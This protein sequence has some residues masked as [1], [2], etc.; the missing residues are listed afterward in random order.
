MS[1]LSASPSDHVTSDLSDS[2]DNEGHDFGGPGTPPGPPTPSVSSDDTLL[3]TV[4]VP[5]ATV[6]Y[7]SQGLYVK[8]TLRCGHSE[9]GPGWWIVQKRHSELHRF[10]KSLKQLVDHYYPRSTMS[11]LFSSSS[12]D[13]LPKFPSTNLLSSTNSSRKMI[14]ARRQGLHDYFAR[15]MEQQHSFLRHREIR[16]LVLSFLQPPNSSSVPPLNPSW[17]SGDSPSH[18]P[19][20]DV[21]VPSYR[22][23]DSNSEQFPVRAPAVH[24]VWLVPRD[25]VHGRLLV[26]LPNVQSVVHSDGLVVAHLKAEP[27]TPRALLSQTYQEYATLCRLIVSQ[28]TLPDAPEV[29]RV[30]DNFRTAHPVVVVDRGIGGSLKR[31]K[32]PTMVPSARSNHLPVDNLHRP[33]RLSFD[34]VDNLDDTRRFHAVTTAIRGVEK[35]TS[36]N[37]T[38]LISVELDEQGMA[39]ARPCR[40][41]DRVL[42]RAHEGARTRYLLSGG[43]QI[44]IEPPKGLGSVPKPF[45]YGSPATKIK[46]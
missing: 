21:V 1:G 31:E 19:I 45:V 20:M 42:C 32:V 24:T 11:K 5:F 10:H 37:S 8:F 39:P 18:R 14:E 23:S 30:L 40:C 15:L 12:L 9:K 33:K 3:P 35:S 26:T 13:A 41:T 4:E 34:A 46:D 2:E 6:F 36:T 27:S 44:V 16:H 38:H 25:L 43:M 22:E 7:T 29:R 28:D 17:G